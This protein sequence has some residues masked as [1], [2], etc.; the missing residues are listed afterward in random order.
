MLLAQ[1]WRST[2]GRGVVI[3]LLSSNIN[4]L[5]PESQTT[6]L[7]AFLFF[8]SLP[9]CCTLPFLLT[10]I[11]PGDLSKMLLLEKQ[12]DGCYVC[13]RQ[14]IMSHRLKSGLRTGTMAW[15]HRF[16]EV[17]Q[18]IPACY[19]IEGNVPVLPM[20]CP[21]VLKLNTKKT[22]ASSPD[23]DFRVLFEDA[24]VQYFKVSFLLAHS[25]IF[26]NTKK[27]SLNEVKNT[28]LYCI[29]SHFTSLLY[30]AVWE[31]SITV[32]LNI[33]LSQQRNT[34]Q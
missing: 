20:G 10:S 1:V 30:M 22:Y 27:I 16:W 33:F 23:K 29:F 9:L 2:E 24:L 32:P 4:K 14:T 3:W 21:Q 7:K 8:Y 31:S 13:C 15:V 17:R 26:W 25:C 5:S 34:R 6:P 18:L 12:V 28:I 19:I 11:L